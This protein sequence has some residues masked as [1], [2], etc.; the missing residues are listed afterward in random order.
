[1]GMTRAAPEFPYGYPETNKPVHACACQWPSQSPFNSPYHH[2][3]FGMPDLLPTDT[4]CPPTMST[5][6]LWHKQTHQRAWQRVSSDLNWLKIASV[7]T[8]LGNNKAF[9]PKYAGMDMINKHPCSVSRYQNC[10]V[11]LAPFHPTTRKGSKMNEGS[12]PQQ[13]DI[14]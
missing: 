8:M 5:V 12:N 4:H 3:P 14:Q 10:T 13:K 11:L 9:L 1:M 7:I 6:R 2:V